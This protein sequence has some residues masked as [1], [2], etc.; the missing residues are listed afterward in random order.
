VPPRPDTVVEDTLPVGK[1]VVTTVLRRPAEA[2]CLL[3]LA[4]GAGAGLRHVF[5]EDLSRALAGHRVATLRFQF[6]YMEAG[7][8]R[9]D[10]AGVLVETVRA[11]VA[12]GADLA[13]GLPLFAGGKSMG[14]RITTQ[15][16]AAE[17]LEGV[18]GIVLFGFPLHPARKP[19]TTRA[20]HLAEV[21]TPMLFLQGTRDALATLD[22]FEP[23]IAELGSRAVCSI[24][25][26]A[27]HGFHVLKRSGR[28]DAEVMDE[29]ATRAAAWMC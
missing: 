13:S 26:G 16:A 12:R 7:R 3:V 9:P 28:T 5:M 15:A 24:I 18:R 6:P 11:A 22:L 2:C 8:R 19:A 23:I 21:E 27:D 29:L 14:G 20:D 4:H 17:A 10:A 1:A 25:D